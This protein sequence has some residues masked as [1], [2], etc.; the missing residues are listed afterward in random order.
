ML[1]YV[2]VL[3]NTRKEVEI[4]LVGRSIGQRITTH[5]DTPMTRRMRDL[6]QSRSNTSTLTNSDKYI[7]KY[8]NEEKFI[9]RDIDKYKQKDKD[10]KDG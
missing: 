5:T 9:D 7:E 2:F 10:K 1:M 3:G 6:N 8:N 4:G